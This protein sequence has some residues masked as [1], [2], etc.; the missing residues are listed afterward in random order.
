MTSARSA[1]R[2]TP[3]ADAADA[4]REARS[5][6]DPDFARSV[7]AGLAAEPKGFEPKYFYDAAGSALFER[8]METPEYYPTR[9]EIAIL[10]AAGP[11]IADAIGPQAI[12]IEPG[13]GAGL[14]TRLLLAALDRPKIFAPIEI[15]GEHLHEA[16]DAMRPDFPGLDITP[17]VGDFTAEIA[18]PAAL[19]PP[20]DGARLLFFPGSTI[21]NFEPQVAGEL[22][23][24][25]RARLA[26]DRLL[27]GFDLEKDPARLIAAYDDAAGVTAAFNKNLLE[28]VNREL[29][30]DFDPDAF[31]HQAR[32]NAAEGRIEMH[33]VSRRAQS[34]SLLGRRFAFTAGESIHTENSYKFSE[35]RFETLAA[36]AGWSLER[37]WTDDEGLFCVALMTA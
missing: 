13:S 10:K 35:K 25:F 26:V 12:L 8:I 33:L 20:S 2:P 22:L 24:R 3:P 17:I 36:K 29:G 14:K 16:M 32:W 11:E 37:R 4:R 5:G 21:G 7:L 18:L 6:P 1:A 34:V 9:T 28:R 31:D 30:G 23:A 15:S 19:R 27:I